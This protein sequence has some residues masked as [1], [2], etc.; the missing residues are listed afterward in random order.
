MCLDHCHMVFAAIVGSHVE[1]RQCICRSCREQ[2]IRTTPYRSPQNLDRPIYLPAFH[3][4]VRTNHAKDAQD[5]LLVPHDPFMCRSVRS[6]QAASQKL[7]EKF[8]VFL[9]LLSDFDF[10]ANAKMKFH[11]M[12]RFDDRHDGAITVHKTGKI[13]PIDCSAFLSYGT[14]FHV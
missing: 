11:L 14:S 13:C 12:V 5:L 2:K 8:D 3:S 7:R 1:P 4:R 10:D 9:E 6:H